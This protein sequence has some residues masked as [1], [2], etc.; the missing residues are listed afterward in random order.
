M[1]VLAGCQAPQV[2]QSI[3]EDW[4]FKKGEIVGAERVDFDAGDWEAVQLPHTFNP[5]GS[6]EVYREQKEAVEY[7][8]P[9]WYRKT[10]FVGKEKKGQRLFV[11]FDAAYLK[12][13]FYVNG[14]HVG[15][16]AGGFSAFCYE[17][18]DFVTYGSDNM[19]AV[20]VDNR[21]DDG[22]TPLGGGYIKFGGIT[23]P[24]WLIEKPPVCISPVHYASTGVYCRQLQVNKAQAELEIETILNAQP[25]VEGEVQVVCLIKD[26]SGK[27]VAKASGT[28]RVQSGQQWAVKVPMVVKNPDL[29]HGLENPA[30]Y[31]LSVQLWHNGEMIDQQVVTTGFKSVRVDR[32]KGFF[33]N[34]KSYPLFGCAQHQYYPGV[35]SAM[36]KEHFDQDAELMKDLGMN[37]V[38]LSH[39][40]HSEYRL[41]LCD[42]DG[43]VAFSEIAMIAKF[44]GTEAFTSNCDQQLKEM[45]YQ[46][47]NH[48][49]IAIW[50]LF[51]E[52]TSDEWKGFNGLDFLSNLNRTAKEIDPSRLTCSVSW[53]AG[54]RNDIADLS[55]WNRYQG[56]YWNAYGGAPNDFSWIEKLREEFPER[57]LG[58]TEY[59]AGGALNHFDEH[60]GY[61]P[62]NKDQFHPQE[63]HTYSH[64][65]HWAEIKKRPWIWGTYIWT[66]TEFLVPSYD[67]GRATYV[68]DKGLVGEHRK[69]FKDAYYF[70]KANW[71]PEPMLHLCEKPFYIRLRNQAQIT[72]YSNVGAVELMVNGKS[73]GTIFDAE[74][75]IYRWKNVPLKPGANSIVVKSGPLQESTVWHHVADI[76]DNAV[77]QQVVPA[78]AKWKALLSEQK[79]TKK[80]NGGV[81]GIPGADGTQSYSSLE[82]VWEEVAKNGT[83]V[84]LPLESQ[85]NWSGVAAFLQKEFIVRETVNEPYLYLKQT[86]RMSQKNPGRVAISI[87]GRNVLTLEE[88]SADFRL[89]PIDERCG[90]LQP[91]QH[92]I[93]VIAEKPEQ[94]GAFDVGLVERAMP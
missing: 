64:E 80:R 13:D 58:L 89:I 34:G 63:F 83:E 41:D 14:K 76:T 65:L 23:R 29:W 31:E 77:L 37:A 28:D 46:L 94:G 56:W 36:R 85:R 82:R 27:Q 35:G 50:G 61:A 20:R 91:G 30:L 2:R 11:R 1:L 42:R 12:S 9:G 10:L 62:F 51:N 19:I 86:A 66:L 47:Y 44:N 90:P 25:H 88:G 22:I 54:E 71:N 8:G 81:T 75:G 60:R 4:K 92:V 53:K 38:R 57:K 24:V 21:F 48:P 26:P 15:T 6:A 16:H 68:H 78:G 32:D 74:Y 18:T 67:Q 87:D 40:P 52:I 49:S 84:T 55:G 73:V 69:Q 3:N 59:S 45:V 70:Y 72:A 39:Y 17:I 43:I 7:M 33:L 79:P 5:S 93:T